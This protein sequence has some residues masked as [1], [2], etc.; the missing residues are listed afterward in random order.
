MSIFDFSELSKELTNTLSKN[1]K[2][3]YG[4]FFTPPQ[5]ISIIWAKILAK[6]PNINPNQILE[7]SCGSGEFLKYIDNTYSNNT[8]ITGIEYNKK[9]FD[10]VSL[11]KFKN[12]VKIINDDFL[13][14]N[15]DS[16]R[17]DLIIGNPPFFVIPKKNV[18]KEMTNYIVGR[19]NIYILFLL[20]SLKLLKNNGCIAF[21][22]PRNFLNC[23]Y[24]NKAR[25]HIKKN[26]E[27]IDIIDLCSDYLE[28]QQKT[29]AIIIQKLKE[30]ADNSSFIFNINNFCIYSTKRDVLL[31]LMKDSTTLN[32]LKMLVKVGNIVWNQNKTL[33]TDDKEQ[34]RLIYSSDIVSNKLV[35]GKIKNNKKHYIRKK[36]IKEP[37]IILNRGYGNGKYKLNHTFINLE[38]PILIE[39]HLICITSLNNDIDLLQR[40]DKSLEDSLTKEFIE[41]YFENNAINVQEL[42]YILPIYKKYIEEYL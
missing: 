14:Y 36:G 3:E 11:I 22:L 7:P 13:R 32:N 28:T 6:I 5:D 24:Y 40:I 8:T 2:K 41:I 17:Y 16:L 30:K 4:I 10:K 39:N 15:F 29:C 19:P 31:N 20:K 37:M 35:E 12:N 9:I 34:T 21:I 23:L 27:I 18:P 33:L 1:E 38:F 26:F 25:E 42:L